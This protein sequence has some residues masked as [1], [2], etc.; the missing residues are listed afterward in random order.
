M[1]PST[2]GKQSRQFQGFFR[3]AT[4]LLILVCLQVSFIP[5]S[6]YAQAQSGQI[7]PADPTCSLQYEAYLA[8]VERERQY[9]AHTGPGSASFL[10]DWN[11]CLKARKTSLRPW[12]NMQVAGPSGWI[13][14]L[15]LIAVGSF[16]FFIGPHLKRVNMLRTKTDQE[17]LFI[18][19]RIE[20]DAYAREQEAE[21]AKRLYENNL[22]R[23]LD[24]KRKY[25]LYRQ[26]NKVL[27]E[28]L[29]DLEEEND[30]EDPGHGPTP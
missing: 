3:I 1:T 13:S 22:E 26:Q 20:L 11:R 8:A 28:M 6:T 16:F 14:L 27:D 24:L 4:S 29:R 2:R 25:A 5:I 21:A 10:S 7:L 23:Q 15:L 19:Q 30:E 18:K 12:R 17:K 9:W